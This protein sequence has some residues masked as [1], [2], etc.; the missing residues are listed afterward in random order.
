ME[1][2]E[3]PKTKSGTYEFKGIPSGDCSAFCWDV[4]KEE[5]VKITGKKPGKYDKS[6]ENKGLYKIYPN[7]FYGF[8]NPM[9][10]MKLSVQVLNS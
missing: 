4:S 6:N 10:L 3:L 9:C 5:Y 7:D 1:N 2:N 8:D